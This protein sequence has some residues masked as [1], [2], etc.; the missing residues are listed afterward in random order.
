MVRNDGLTNIGQV[1]GLDNVLPVLLGKIEAMG[2]GAGRWA[3]RRAIEEGPQD[4]NE[5]PLGFPPSASTNINNIWL[6]LDRAR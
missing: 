6:Q 5:I 4:L 3:P 1:A 2:N